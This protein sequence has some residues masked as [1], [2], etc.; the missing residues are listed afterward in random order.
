M[1]CPCLTALAVR[2]AFSLRLFRT[3]LPTPVP[4]HY[5]PA[6]VQESFKQAHELAD[7]KVALA[8][9]TYDTVRSFSFRTGAWPAGCPAVLEEM[10]SAIE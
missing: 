4:V 5:R 6:A 8:V 10:S 9:Q 2:C 1:P 3:A 7:R